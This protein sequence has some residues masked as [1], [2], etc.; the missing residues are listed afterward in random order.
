M[1]LA[2]QQKLNRY[3]PI[4]SAQS[5]PSIENLMNIRP[6][7]VAA[8]FQRIC[9]H[10]LL[11]RILNIIARW[12]LRMAMAWM[13]SRRWLRVKRWGDNME[14][15]E[16]DR[17]YH[18]PH[19]NSFEAIYYCTKYMAI[20]RSPRP[21]THQRPPS[22]NVLYFAL[23][24]S[25]YAPVDGH[26]IA[27]NMNRVHTTPAV[28]FKSLHVVLNRLCSVRFCVKLVRLMATPP[29]S[30]ILAIVDPVSV[31]VWPPQPPQPTTSTLCRK[32]R[33]QI[34]SDSILAS[35]VVCIHI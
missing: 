28:C 8:V 26:N 27:G 29:A 32:P 6:N 18:Y 31:A 1:A 22:S 10:L 21:C 11:G 13:P 35:S 25:F 30:V 5:C 12:L 24:I 3:R 7:Q 4:F 23:C 2:H 14:N 16:Q 19:Y 17:Y 20:R 9:A 33:C 15:K 34:T